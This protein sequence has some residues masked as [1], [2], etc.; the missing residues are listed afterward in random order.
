M[1]QSE[2][3]EELGNIT[4][5]KKENHSYCCKGKGPPPSPR[6]NMDS[7]RDI[8]N[9]QFYIDVYDYYYRKGFWSIILSEISDIILI[10]CGTLFFTFMCVLLDWNQILKCGS[11]NLIQDCGELRIYVKPIVPNFFFLSVIFFGIVSCV[12][13]IVNFVF[14]FKTLSNIKH[15][16]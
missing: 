15:Y 13:K 6:M 3:Y 10:I 16:Y 9:E 5:T 12:Y 4:Q 14:Y 11:D 2:N 7:P 1:N 8:F